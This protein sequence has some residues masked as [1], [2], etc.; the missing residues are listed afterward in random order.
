MAAEIDFNFWCEPFQFEMIAFGNKESGLGEIIFGGDI[1]HQLH[2]EP[3]FERT[4]RRR[5]PAEQLARKSIDLI[6][7]YLHDNFQFLLHARKD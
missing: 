4:N 1:L 7:G 2:I 3:L 6:N 5:I